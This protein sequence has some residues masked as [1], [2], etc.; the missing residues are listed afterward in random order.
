M[1]PT[2][3]T[4]LARLQQQH[5]ARWDIWTVRSQDRT[6]WCVKPA[7]TTIAVHDEDS[8]DHLDTWIHRVDALTRSGITIQFHPGY[9]VTATATWTSP[10][11]TAPDTYGPAPVPDVLNHAED[12]RA[13]R[14]GLIHWLATAPEQTARQLTDAQ[15]H[16]LIPHV[17]DDNARRVLIAILRQHAGRR[18]DHLARSQPPTSP[19]AIEAAMTP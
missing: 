10:G 13:R 11:S 1:T 5:A 2:E 6:A 18:E 17:P 4:R 8:P 16:D 7:G 15:I 9:H 12:T 3:D 14:A 19:L